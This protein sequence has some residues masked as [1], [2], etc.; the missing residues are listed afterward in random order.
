MTS[1]QKVLQGAPAGQATSHRITGW[2][3]LRIS[4]QAILHRREDLACETLQLGV[5][6]AHLRHI[7]VLIW[8]L[9]KVCTLEKLHLDESTVAEENTT[10]NNV[11]GFSGYQGKED[12]QE[13]HK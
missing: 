11:V 13:Q 4:E 6:N 2:E 8:L 3:L 1:A 7:K 12:G 9:P 10:M 5:I